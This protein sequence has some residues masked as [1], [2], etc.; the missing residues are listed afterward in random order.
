[1]SQDH[2]LPLPPAFQEQI[3]LVRVIGHLEPFLALLSRFGIG[4][5]NLKTIVADLKDSKQQVTDLAKL[6]EGFHEAFSELGW[7]ISES[8]NIETAKA[9]LAA[10][11]DC[12]IED[13]EDLLATDYEG[14]R[15]HFVVTRLCQTKGFKIRRELLQEALTLTQETRYLAAAPLLFIIADGVGEDVFHKSIFSS[16]VNLEE[17]HSLAGQPDALPKLICEICRIRRKTTRAHISFPYRNGILHGRYLGYGNRLVTA[18]CWS[19]LSNIADVIR[20]REAEEALIP[21]S[22]PSLSETLTNYVQTKELSER[23]D[24][25]TPR[26]V[27]EGRINVFAESEISSFG[28]DEP[29][30]TLVEFLQAWKKNNFGRMGAL[31][32]YFDKR[33]INRR[34]GEIR[35]MMQ[36]LTLIDAA[37]IR[38][39]DRAPAVTEIMADL[40]TCVD[41]AK[42]TD[43]FNFIMNCVDDVEEVTI[44]GEGAAH[45]QVIPFYQDWAIRQRTLLD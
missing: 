16:G 45:W 40:T 36:D 19:L 5:D 35:E 41:S 44:R 22:N 2:K 13:A 7:L 42:R 17:L 34:A 9:A 3:N 33:A 6:I 25:W 21:P 8:T 43:R 18:K 10:H 1:M 37:I 15:L 24:A 12:R 20:A 30:A 32:V 28:S 23:I 26:P 31:T 39:K 14:E 27:F 38:I 29:E 11:E 4:G